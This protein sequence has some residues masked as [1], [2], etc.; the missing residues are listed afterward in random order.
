MELAAFSDRGIGTRERLE[1][2]AADRIIETA[3]GLA[4]QVALVCDGA[5]G[6]EA[7]EL[8]ARLTSRTIFEYLEIS[9]ETVVPQ[10]L[11][12]AVEQANKAVYDEL[13]GAGTGTVALA[14]V[15]LND[16]SAPYGRL[17]IAHVGNS[18]IYLMREGRMGR[19]NIDHTLANEY[20]YAGQMSAEE[21]RQLDASDYVTRS[22]GVG[23]EV[24]VD[25]GFYAERGKNFVNS[26]R[27]FRIG[28]MGMKLQEGDTIF[29]ASDGLF[30]YINEE[31]FLKHALDDNV[32][33][34][35]RTLLK[36]AADRG[37]ED[38]IALSLVFVPSRNRRQ[39]R[40]F[41]RFSSRQRAGI[42][43]FLLA[44]VMLI[45]ILGLR[46]AGGES[47]R[48]ALLITQ[49][50][51]Q[52]VILA[53]SYTPTPTLPPP[54]VTPTL[55]VVEGQ[56]GNRFS[57]SQQTGLAVFAGRYIDPL[58]PD[59]INRIEIA[60][61]NA[62]SG[63]QDINRANLYLELGSSIRL[64]Q[65]IDTPGSERID[66]ILKRGSDIF[67][68]PGIFGSGG[69][70]IGLEQN[71]DMRL[72]SQNACMSVRQISADATKPNDADKVA[73]TCYGG[74]CSYHFPNSD[75]EAVA[76]G[77]QALLD[78]D[79]QQLISTNPADPAQVL[80]YS[81]TI[82]QLSQREDQ[83]SCLSTWLDTDNDTVNYPIDECPADAGSAAGKGCPDQD[84]DGIQD[85][86]DQCPAE[87]GPESNNGCPLP[88]LDDDGLEG[89]VDICPFDAGLPE[90][91]GCPAEGPQATQRVIILTQMVADQIAATPIMTPTPTV[92]PTATSIP[93]PV[94]RDDDY[95]TLGS[96]VLSISSPGVLGNDTLNGAALTPLNTTTSEGGT[97]ALDRGGG[98]NYT[99]PEDFVGVDSF[100]YTLTGENGT[101]S[102][103]VTINVLQP[104]LAEPVA[105]F[106][107]SPTNGFV[108]LTV[109]IMNASTGPINSYRWDFGDGT[110][111]S[112]SSDPGSHIYDTPGNFTITLTVTGPGGSDSMSQSVAVIAQPPVACFAP[113]SSTISVNGSVNFDATCSTGS[114]SS[115][116]WDFG[117]GSNGTG[118]TTSHTFTTA[119]IFTVTLTVTGPS[120]VDQAVGTVNAQ[121]PPPLA[122]FSPVN[123]NI[124]VNGTVNFNA[125]CS[126]GSITSYNWDFGN[127]IVPNGGQAPSR[128]YNAAG[129]FNV[130]LTVVGPGGSDDF[131][132][133]VNVSSLPVACFTPTNTTIAPNTSVAFNA[134]CS[135]PSGLTFSWSF[136]DGTT[137][138][139]QTPTHPYTTAGT[140]TVVLTVTGTGGVQDTF[141][142][143]VRVG[144]VPIAVTDNYQ[145]AMNGVLVAPAT[146]PPVVR[147]VLFN[148]T[149]NG[150][151]ITSNTN[152]SNGVL[153]FNRVTG[154][155][156]YTPNTNTA[157]PD[158][159][160]YTLANAVGTA[161]G[162]TNICVNPIATDDAYATSINTPLVIVAP[163]PRAND[164]P[165]TG[166]TVTFPATT[167]NGTITGTSSAGAFTFT[168]NA[169]FTGT[170]TFN[171]TLN[172][173]GCTDTGTVTI[174]VLAANTAPVATNNAF[175]MVEGT[176]FVVPAPGVMADDNNGDGG[177]AGFGIS[178]ALVT[179]PVSGTLVFNADGSFT[180]TPIVGFTG[181]LTFTYQV[182]DGSLTSNIATVTITVIANN[183]PLANNNTYN[184]PQNITLTVPALTGVLAN[185][186]DA[187]ADPLTAVLGTTVLSG[188]LTLNPNGSFTY[189]PATGFTGVASFTYRAFDGAVNSNL[190]TVTISVGTANTP[191]IAVN[192]SYTMSAPTTTLTVNA[193]NGVRAN[194]IDLESA[195]NTLTVAL[196]ANVT[197]GTLTLNANG[198]FNYTPNVGFNG[199]DTFTYQV[200]DPAGGISNTATVMIAVD[201]NTAPVAV[202]DAYTVNQNNALFVPP[203]GVLGNDT[204]IDGNATIVAATIVSNPANGFIFFNLDGSFDYFPNF[205]FFGTDAF[206]YRAVDTLGVFS[207]V[208]VV[209]ITVNQVPTPTD[210]IYATGFNTPLNANVLTNDQPAG[211]TVLAPAPTF[212]F[213]GGT[214]VLAA[215]G[216]LNYT[217]PAFFFGQDFF[218]YQITDGV[219]V[220]NP[221]IVIINVGFN[222]PPTA[223]NDAYT[224]AANTALVRNAAQGV[225]VN[226][227][228]PDGNNLESYV[229]T[230]PTN[231]TLVLN[232][233]GSFTYTP[234]PG[235]N[236]PDTFAYQA[237]DGLDFSNVAIVTI[238]VGVGGGNS[239]PVANDDTYSTTAARILR[240]NAPGVLRNDTDANGDPLTAN[241]VANVN[242]GTLVFNT[243]GSFVYTPPNARF[244][245]IVTFTYQA[246]DTAGALSAIVTVTIAVSV[247][248][249]PPVP[250][251]VPAPP[252]ATRCTDTNF[253]NPGMIRSNFLDDEDRANLFCRLIAANGSYM[254]WLGSP[255]TNGGNIGNR[256][257]IDL[258]LIAAVDVFSMSGVTRFVNDVNICLQGSGYIIFMDVNGQPRL[259]QLW[260]NWTTPSFPG[261]TCT[262]LYAPGTVILVAN[263]PE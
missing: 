201:S 245:G 10:L 116:S 126:T 44:I 202:N 192:N 184:T 243:D 85:S 107:L 242:R 259:P 38:N 91:D 100:T 36:Y 4:L 102:G 82:W 257:V 261:Y 204:D 45:G 151:T 147:T 73:L 88:D 262:T 175:T 229:A 174:Q 110:L 150:A 75:L 12:R 208:A 217:P 93:L 84:N 254:F 241:L 144:N 80:A 193:A 41:E 62:L 51:V 109:S 79:N 162:T 122:C 96:E 49:T 247:P 222:T 71:P 158:S 224:T 216:A 15:H 52:Q 209:T 135:S 186:F 5:G 35:T 252:P 2:Y 123:S 131:F 58:Q 190:A 74:S 43:V 141:N 7:G 11:I 179:A 8:A 72:Q 213:Y 132:G 136:G 189:I 212:S 106:T 225:L 9:T 46:V 183:A 27:A 237:T 33:R 234:N 30:P 138:S 180:Y 188:T 26:R 57:P 152:T 3:G 223:N 169:G 166:T 40:T 227:T 196:V 143:T 164:L 215:N 66:L 238:T 89:N 235:Y 37:P 203:N 168:P 157:G 77:Q 178:A 47:Q 260:S 111:P 98:F 232:V 97:I 185:D 20:I 34:A 114:I 246:S 139:G 70:T 194:D 226:D 90:N 253:E 172:V 28:Q 199:V 228:D 146:G 248:P 87:S 133:S 239:P 173:G 108:P 99:P 61:A 255:I 54:S 137:G 187:D 134:G 240:V 140:Y 206:T 197:N 39:V 129:I 6:G 103:Q 256:N 95:S 86:V 65:V 181:P 32:E 170:N 120:G 160:T 24:N 25:I 128:T 156:T 250:I 244:R 63:G 55:P 31:E 221:A 21:A 142:G 211:V 205:G 198:S 83:L 191:P 94:A 163:G 42:A 81:E 119:S 60:G 233:N 59:E 69:V 121:L 1:D 145:I 195:T 105:D 251:E 249:P 14:A 236:G 48:A 16:E 149:L 53:A 29:T 148:D 17:Y 113:L 177:A 23:A 210:D 18:R 101:D 56:V 231:G 115:Y 176:T 67:I 219:I 130:R 214:V 182:N 50:F 104:P 153:N 13:R 78:V 117:D 200:T 171:Y 218:F 167:A 263:K 165:T 230:P 19:L 207:N 159:F 155:F 161:V 258:G 76:S 118:Q 22:I 68:N 124:S 154:G 112:A 125:S 220:S 127:G 64:N 92:T